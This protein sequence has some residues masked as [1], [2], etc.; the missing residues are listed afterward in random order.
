MKKNHVA[1]ATFREHCVVLAELVNALEVL[2]TCNE[3]CVEEHGA[4]EQSTIW[5]SNREEEDYIEEDL[6]TAEDDDNNSPD[7]NES[8]DNSMINSDNNANC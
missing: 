5:T 7:I 6:V 3:R 8:E 2:I 1:D 4:V